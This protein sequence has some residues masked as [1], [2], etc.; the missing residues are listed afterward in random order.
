MNKFLYTSILLII[1]AICG[2]AVSS[3]G[4]ECYDQNQE[5]KENH[6]SNYNFIVSFLVF[7]IFMCLSGVVAGF[8]AFKELKNQ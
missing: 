8:F 7:N 3:I 2:I 4:T 1:T 5:F 6:K